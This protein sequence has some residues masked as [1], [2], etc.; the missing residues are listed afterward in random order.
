MTSFHSPIV[1]VA[2]LCRKVI[3]F[4]GIVNKKLISDSVG[5][6]PPRWGTLLDRRDALIGV[7]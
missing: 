2:Y 3:K 5:W 6:S 1:A 4:G 7:F